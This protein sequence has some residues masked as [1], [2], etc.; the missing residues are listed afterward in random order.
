MVINFSLHLHH[1]LY[2]KTYFCHYKTEKYNKYIIQNVPY[3]LS[4]VFI[5]YMNSHSQ[6]D[7][8]AFMKLPQ[9]KCMKDIICHRTLSKLIKFHSY[10]R[11]YI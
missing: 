1:I 9:N 11:R 4:I 10:S 3:C 7:L 2:C 5:L 6:R 8:I